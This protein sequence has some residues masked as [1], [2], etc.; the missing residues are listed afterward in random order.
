MGVE[1]NTYGREIP[2]MVKG[3]RRCGPNG[4]IRKDNGVE[5]LGK[6][7]KI[8]KRRSARDDRVKWTE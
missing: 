7:S 2:N 6:A 4:W 5:S 3:V 8:V 1:K